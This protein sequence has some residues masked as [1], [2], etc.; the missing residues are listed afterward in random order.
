MLKWIT[1]KDY[2]S[3]SL[4]SNT[5]VQS[6]V[7][8]RVLGGIVGFQFEFTVALTGTPTSAADIEAAVNQIRVTDVNRNNVFQINGQDVP[9]LSY[10]NSPLG[11]FTTPTT[12]S[13]TSATD[14]FTLYWPVR[15]EDQPL[16]ITTTIDTLST[17]SGGGSTAGTVDFVVNMIYDDASDSASTLRLT[18]NDSSLV[19]GTNNISNKLGQNLTTIHISLRNTANSDTNVTSIQ[20]EGGGSIQIESMTVSGFKAYEAAKSVS[21]HQ[22]GYFPIPMSQP[23][24]TS[25]SSLLNVVTGGSLT[26]RLYQF[27]I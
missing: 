21:G 5:Q 2:G 22:A 16:T 18:N 4:T 23:F 27:Y 7:T 19:S 11:V 25:S 6:D 15:I 10:N 24:V 8:P 26:C 14:Q 12:A 3:V 20:L 17:V 1:V 13:T 9:Y